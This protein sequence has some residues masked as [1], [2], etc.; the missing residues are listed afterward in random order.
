[1]KTSM[2]GVY[3][4][5]LAVSL[6]LPL[7]G[8]EPAQEDRSEKR[9]EHIVGLNA[10]G[11]LHQVFG[12][13][14]GTGDLPYLIT[15]AWDAGKMHLRGGLGPEFRNETVV[16][17]GFTDS[18][19][20]T[21]LDLEWRTGLGFEVLDE[22]KWGVLA[23]IDVVGSYTL[24]RTTNDSGFDKITDEIETWSLGGGPFI[25][26]GYRLSQRISLSA[27]SALYARH[28]NTTHS[29]LFEN[30]PDFNNELSETTGQQLDT[31]LPTSLFL[32]FHF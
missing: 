11:L 10:T 30:F 6:A 24:D 5:V 28:F 9:T 22:E 23:G 27:E 20:Q 19:K 7:T 12:D 26:L 32:H 2:E 13:S 16:H 25:Q 14:D 29:E 3:L 1:M 4:L 21:F 17:E 31:F 18:E 15:Y 8:Q